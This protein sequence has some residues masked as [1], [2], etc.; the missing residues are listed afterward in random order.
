[1][2]MTHE[3][4]TDDA[5]A[6]RVSVSRQRVSAQRAASTLTQWT[7]KEG[8]AFIYNHSIDYESDNLLAIG[9][10]TCICKFCKAKKWKNEMDGICCAAG[11]VQLA[12]L[13]RPTE[14]LLALLVG[15]HP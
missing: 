2:R 6:N 14:F 10:M 7:V 3:H 15:D 1:M 5:S 12:P 4:E 11:K 13:R 9:A 8:S